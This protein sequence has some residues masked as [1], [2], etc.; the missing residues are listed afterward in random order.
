MQDVRTY[1]SVL[2]MVLVD[3]CAR[4]PP[5]TRAHTHTLARSQGTRVV[6][7]VR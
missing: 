6:N 3:T 7:S 5:H 1:P 2:D 4:I